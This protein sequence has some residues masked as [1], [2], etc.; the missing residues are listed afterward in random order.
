MSIYK[1]LL[2]GET[3]LSP[4]RLHGELV[5]LFHVMLCPTK[6]KNFSGFPQI[7]LTSRHFLIPRPVWK[8][9]KIDPIF[10]D[11]FSAEFNYNTQFSSFWTLGYLLRA[12]NKIIILYKKKRKTTKIFHLRWLHLWIMFSFSDWPTY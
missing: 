3:L 6:T 1:G 11:I 10:S 4:H 9:V 5:K 12:Q 8:F 2:L 7:A